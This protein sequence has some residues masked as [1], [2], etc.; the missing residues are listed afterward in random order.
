MVIWIFDPLEHLGLCPPLDQLHSEHLVEGI[1]HSL[2]IWPG[3]PQLKQESSFLLQLGVLAFPLPLVNALISTSLSS[4]VKVSRVLTSIA[5][6][7]R[8]LEDDPA[9]PRNWVSCCF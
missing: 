8:C 3:F 5:L 7:S 1:L 6:G 4:S 2:A 9:I